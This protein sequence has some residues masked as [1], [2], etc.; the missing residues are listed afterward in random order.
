MVFFR[1]AWQS[2]TRWPVHRPLRGL[3]VG[4]RLLSLYE[5]SGTKVPWLSSPVLGRTSFLSARLFEDTPYKAKAGNHVSGTPSSAS[6]EVT[7]RWYP[8]LYLTCHHGLIEAIRFSLF[9]LFA[10]PYLELIF[11]V[12]LTQ[13]SL[14]VLLFPLVLVFDDTA[15]W[16]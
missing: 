14:L 12:A 1:Y 9:P 13:F 16:S 5:S 3:P 2:V 6:D 8:F 4:V 15:H 10:A 7:D 11:R